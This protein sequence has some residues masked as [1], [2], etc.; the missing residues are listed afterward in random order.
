MLA[1]LVTF[2]VTFGAGG[3]GHHRHHPAHIIPPG[4]IS[5][6]TLNVYR[7][8]GAERRPYATLY[9]GGELVLRLEPGTYQAEAFFNGSIGAGPVPCGG[10]R[11]LHVSRHER[12][13]RV[14]LEC[15]RK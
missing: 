9:E 8:V 13:K 15:S 12:S 2:L 10:P 7:Y 6:S 14:T 3:L 4:G 11:T 5:D 1:T